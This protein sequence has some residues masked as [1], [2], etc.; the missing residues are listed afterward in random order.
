MTQWQTRRELDEIKMTY[1]VKEEQ[2]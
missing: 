2:E 1:W